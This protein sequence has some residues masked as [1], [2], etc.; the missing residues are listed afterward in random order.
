MQKKIY[1]STKRMPA[2]PWMSTQHN[3]DLTN[4][5]KCLGSPA[6]T[7]KHQANEQQTTHT[8]KLRVHRRPTDT[9]HAAY[10]V[11][12]HYTHYWPTNLHLPDHQKP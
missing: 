7:P 12:A 2:L 9:M 5:A 3:P 6:I 10:R 4:A 1:K 11:M 8:A